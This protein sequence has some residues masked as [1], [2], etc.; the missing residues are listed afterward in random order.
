MA[1]T[2]QAT[3]L[4]AFMW[5]AY[6]LNYSDRQAI[7]SIFPSLKA[8]LGMTDK[9]LGLTGTIFL[10]VYA[11]S[12]PIAGYIA[13]RFSKRI[14]IILS[15]VTWSIVTIATGFAGSAII[16]LGLRAM[17]G[18]SESMFMPTAIALTANA[19]PP[20]LRS[21]AIA[22]LTT[23]QIVGTIAGSWFGGW[24]ADQG[25]WRE[26]FLVLGLVGL[27]YTIPYSLFLRK[28]KENSS[29]EIKTTVKKPGFS[30]L[31]KVH[32]FL[33]LCIVFPIFVFGLWLLYGWLPTFLHDKF[34]LNQSDAALN[35]TVFVQV[36]TLIG[37]LGG[38][39]IADAL[40]HRTK[41]SRL[42]MLTASLI[43][44]APFLHVLGNS[45]TL[46]TTRFAAMVFGLFSGFM[47]GN[48]FPAA[49]DVVPANARASAV[50]FLNFFGA[51]LS[52]F[53]TLFGGLWKQSLGIDG[54]L[55]VTALAYVIAGIAMIIG[56]KKLFPKDYKT[57]HLEFENF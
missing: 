29:P 26:A 11:I 49:F 10:W 16:I 37:L 46:N 2:R 21:R 24:M 22:I 54:L 55:S 5:V 41:A 36:P 30:A 1:S 52:G 50:G 28:V 56:I 48:I 34:T 7:F 8:D 3:L 35:A 45:D 27:L 15:L 44:C 40:Y 19:H 9:Q 12:C 25:Q 42:W 33:L 47:M 6:F 17:M 43:L 38:G 4:V 53:A 51:I 23:A 20:S 14:L 32:T 13:D 39:L 57:E 18:I 31:F